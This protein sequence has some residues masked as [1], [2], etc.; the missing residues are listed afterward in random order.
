MPRLE[1]NLK[2]VQEAKPVSGGKRYSLT[3]SEAEFREEKNDI[4]IS[5]GIDDH[6][7]AP[8]V[9]HFCSLPKSDDDDR[10][11]QFKALMMKRFLV[12]FNIPHDDD[13]FDV[14]DFPGATA[15]LELRLSD[16]DDNGNVYNRLVLPR[17]KDEGDG[18]VAEEET[19]PPAARTAARRP[20][21]PARA[22][23]SRAA[24]ARRR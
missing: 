17:L 22:A 11:A 4:R 19:P 13:G 16:P 3:I 20:A 21:T 8:N 7:D 1:L 14:E 5:I 15:E 9:S 18:A 10:K 12:A 23:A 24:P 2:D 6:L